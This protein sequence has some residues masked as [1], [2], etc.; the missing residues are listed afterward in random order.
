MSSALVWS[1]ESAILGLWAIVLSMLYTNAFHTF[2]ARSFA[3]IAAANL[4]IQIIVTARDIPVSHA[5]SEAFICCVSALFLVYITA[6][7]DYKNNA[8]FTIA[9]TTG[10]LI[11]ID[12]CI[13][14]AWFCASYV[15]ALGMVFSEKK[16]TF[17]MFHHYGYHVTVVMPSL[18]IVWLYNYDGSNVKWIIGKNATH[19]ILFLIYACLWGSFIT[20]QIISQSV[21]L[22]AM[23]AWED[24]TFVSGSRYFIS[25]IFKFLGRLGC[26]VIPVSA[27]LVSKSR[28]HL[29]ISWILTAIAASNA[30][31]WAETISS[32]F[33]AQSAEPVQVGIRWRDKFV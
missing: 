16:K 10:F 21:K 8:Y 29:I 3:L 30:I 1:V 25:V 6:L 23:I 20:F 7:V 2:I 13:G 17:L 15:S 18:L 19:F 26:F 11:P 5:V 22:N 32:L 14:L 31:D 27:I 4:L 33:P 9:D 12:G 24:L 28:E